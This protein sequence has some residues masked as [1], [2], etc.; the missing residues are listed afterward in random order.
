[1]IDVTS[2]V[3]MFL[4]ISLFQY[5]CP[6]LREEWLGTAGLG[7]FFSSITFRWYSV[8]CKEEMGLV[9]ITRLRLNLI[10]VYIQSAVITRIAAIPRTHP[11]PM[12]TSFN[13]PYRPCHTFIVVSRTAAYAFLKPPPTRPT[14]T[15]IPKDN[16]C[17]IFPLL[18]VS[19]VTN[20]PLPQ[21]HELTFTVSIWEKAFSHPD[22]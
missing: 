18:K 17:G 20:H 10:I 1:M 9:K 14:P 21:F 12:S 2:P 4:G 19:F 11:A 22:W 8:T 7:C 3:K 5:I 6:P 13:Q 15:R 16:V